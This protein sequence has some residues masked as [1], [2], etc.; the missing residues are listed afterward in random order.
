M[1]EALLKALTTGLSIWEHK[2][3]NKYLDR[4]IKL[5]KDWY[6]EY[7]KELSLRDH[8][9]LDHIERELCIITS[10]W[11]TYVRAQNS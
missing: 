2:E 10:E 6:E 9:V 5:K 1:I 11:T 4:V 7:E 8:A 3:K